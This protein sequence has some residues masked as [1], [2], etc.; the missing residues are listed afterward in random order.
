MGVILRLEE[1]S[2]IEE[3]DE[4]SR[5]IYYKIGKYL[6]DNSL[7]EAEIILFY[8][9]KYKEKGII[10]AGYL[11]IVFGLTVSVSDKVNSDYM[12]LDKQIL[13]TWTIYRKLKP[14]ENSLELLSKIIAR[15]KMWIDVEHMSNH[16]H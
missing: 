13:S 12:I 7:S 2:F 9:Q 11:K 14:T 15:R 1:F 6:Q 10:L 8:P 4:K 5:K 16:L 3:L